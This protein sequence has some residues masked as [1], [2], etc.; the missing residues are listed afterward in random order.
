M[1]VWPPVGVEGLGFRT[2]AKGIG[3]GD[4]EVS[5]DGG[6]ACSPD[7]SV[8]HIPSRFRRHASTPP[9]HPRLAA[10]IVAMSIFFIVII[11]SNARFAAAGLGSVMALVKA[12]GV[13]CQE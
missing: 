11:A 13:I 12:S 2:A 5:A 9:P 10:S 4:A 1:R 8:S 3:G 6:I 7:H